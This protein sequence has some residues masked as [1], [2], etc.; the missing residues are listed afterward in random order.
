M[1]RLRGGAA[2]R[3]GVTEHQVPAREL[4]RGQEHEM[5]HT[6]DPAMARQ[7]ALD[8]LAE[9]PDYYRHLD[10]LENVVRTMKSR[11]EKQRIMA[12]DILR[13]TRG[14]RTRRR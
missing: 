2:E 3:L 10:V 14:T 12:E 7:I 5:E 13:G 8:H 11:S 9:D 6:D 4:A 1:F